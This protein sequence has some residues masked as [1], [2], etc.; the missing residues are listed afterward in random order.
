MHFRGTNVSSQESKSS[1]SADRFPDCSWE[2]VESNVSC[3]STVNRRKVSLRWGEVRWGEVRQNET[4]GQKNN[5]WRPD[6]SAARQTAPSSEWAGGSW[7]CLHTRQHHLAPDQ[8]QRLLGLF[9]MLA[10]NYWPMNTTSTTTTRKTLDMLHIITRTHINI[11]I[12]MY[13]HKYT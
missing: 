12:H 3:T 4:K 5:W 2:S 9:G 7:L 11:N 10:G 6:A 13:T 8:A 1:Y